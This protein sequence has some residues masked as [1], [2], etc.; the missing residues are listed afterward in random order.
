MITLMDGGMDEYSPEEQL[1]CD[2]EKRRRERRGW[3][4]KGARD[5]P[6]PFSLRAIPP[7]SLPSS[8]SPILQRRMSTRCSAL[9]REG[10]EEG[11]G[12]DPLPRREERQREERW[13]GGGGVTKRLMDDQWRGIDESFITD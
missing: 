6:S 2:R 13:E 7:L 9:H 3:E 5:P 12:G 4:G 1:C 8:L 11:E 10:R